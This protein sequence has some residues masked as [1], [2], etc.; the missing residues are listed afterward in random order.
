MATVRVP[1]TAKFQTTKDGDIESTSFSA[2][3][4]VT[5][6]QTWD[7]FYLIKDDGGHYYTVTKDKIEL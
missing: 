5:I 2:G 6:V 4:E 3:T 1:F 7:K